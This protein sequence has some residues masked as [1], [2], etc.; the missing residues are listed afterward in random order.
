MLILKCNKNLKVVNAIKLN[1]E[2]IIMLEIA[3]LLGLAIHCI[4]INGYVYCF[5][6]FKLLFN[7]PASIEDSI[8]N[9][10]YKFY[11]PYLPVSPWQ[12]C[13]DSFIYFSVYR[14]PVILKCLFYNVNII[15]KLLLRIV[16]YIDIVFSGFNVVF[17]LHTQIL[18]L[19]RTGG[20]PIATSPAVVK[21]RRADLRSI[22]SKRLK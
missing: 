14:Y 8:V 12:L 7:H 21:M 2:M 1:L 15:I 18:Q 19:P 17:S 3:S 10:M 4:L 11:L 20:Q 5:I 22:L 6:Y 9:E 13:P 16:A